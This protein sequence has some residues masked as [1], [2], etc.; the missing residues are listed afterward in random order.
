MSVLQFIASLVSSLSW[1][2]VVIAVV[3]VFRKPLSAILG[4]LV[5]RVSALTKVA[6]GSFEAEFAHRAADLLTPADNEAPTERSGRRNSVSSPVEGGQRAQLEQAR[7]LAD[8]DPRA[9][10][11]AAAQTLDSS[12]AAVTRDFDVADVSVVLSPEDAARLQSLRELRNAAI[13]DTTGDITRQSALQYIVAV[14]RTVAAL[15]VGAATYSA[16]R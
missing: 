15:D 2:L 5:A 1:P 8:I 14:E 16:R 7:N 12:A 9:A 4:Q 13:T 10:V 6:A 3:L 11:L